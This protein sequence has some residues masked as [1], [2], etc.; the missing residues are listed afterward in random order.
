[1]KVLLKT[2]IF[3]WFY[4][5]DKVQIRVEAYALLWE[6]WNTMNDFIF[7]KPNAS[8]CLQLIPL[9]THRIRMWSFLQ[10][11]ERREDMISRCNHLLAA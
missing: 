6:I 2:G 11:E 5:K 9:A 1:M 10:P 4:K 3:M 7:N 8:L